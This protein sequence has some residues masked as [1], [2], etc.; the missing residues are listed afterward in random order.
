MS[1][2]SVPLTAPLEEYVKRMVR[3][4]YAST[5]ADV[6]RRALTRFIEEDAIN[7]VLQAEQ[8]A[9]EG[10]VLKGNLHKLLKALP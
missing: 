6:L 3:C 10:K 5:K 1:T 8:E 4:G 7:A 9:R 2:L